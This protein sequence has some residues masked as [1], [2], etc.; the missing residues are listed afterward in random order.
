MNWVDSFAPLTA[1]QAR[2][3]REDFQSQGKKLVFTNGCFD[4]LHAGHVRYLQQARELGDA[5]IVGLNSD[6][7]VRKLKGP[8]RPVNSELDRAEVLSALRAVDGVVIFHDKRATGLI[9]AIQ[10]HVYAKGGDYTPESLDPDE[11]A[12]LQRAGTQIQILS[13]VPGRSTTSILQR[14]QSPLPSA[15]VL[16]EK[17]P[18]LLAVLGS[19]KGSN[20]RA[21]LSAIDSGV[22]LAQVVVAISDLP[23]SPF[24]Q[25]ARAAG[26]PAHYLH[27]GDH[28][29]KFDLKAQYE[30]VEMLRKAGADL[31]VLAGFMRILKS[32]VFEAFEGRIVNIHPSLLPSHKGATAVRD[33]LVAGDEQ[34]G[35][36][37]HLVTPEIDSGRILAQA[38]VPI[39]PGDD[40]ESLHARI[41]EQ[42]HRLLPQVLA[43]WHQ[44]QAH[45]IGVVSTSC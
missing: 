2:I 33:A 31:V 9:D 37:V 14:V 40:E 21:I 1:E 4:L 27:P 39:Q 3:M 7:S 25:T 16:E 10:P 11:L 32:P 42:E 38:H 19:G 28:P 43:H 41:Q 35:C 24:L 44:L 12:A 6:E 5:L 13:L 34:T 36:T 29:R 23:D 20:L 26:V 8:T 15:G 45:Q 22:L 30:L 17:K 18:L